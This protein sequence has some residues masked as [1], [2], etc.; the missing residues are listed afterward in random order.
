MELLELYKEENRDILYSMSWLNKNSIFDKSIGSFQDIDLFTF[1]ENVN[2]FN[3][4]KDTFYDDIYYILEYTQ[5]TILYLI[6]N[7]N[8]EI[9][10]EHRVMPISQAKEFDRVSILWL[11]RK[12]GRT[13][14]EKLSGGKI[15]AVQRY[16]NLDTYE[17]RIFKI[18]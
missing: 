5:D 1:L 9:K 15:K 16:S 4:K 11:S 6:K 14:K 17:N 7:I 3:Y 2:K 18:L 8:R 12:N 13:L 10:R